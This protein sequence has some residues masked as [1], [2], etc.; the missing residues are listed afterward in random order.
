MTR[1]SKCGYPGSGNVKPVASQWMSGVNNGGSLQK[2]ITIGCERSKGRHLKHYRQKE[3][4][5]RWL[6]LLG[7][8]IHSRRSLSYRRQSIRIWPAASDLEM[9]YLKSITVRI[10]Q[11][12]KIYC[13][14]SEIYVRRYFKSRAYL[15]RLRTYRYA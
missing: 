1:N 7:A 12:L 10:A 15:Y 9:H 14:R 5:S 8:A 2:V 13:V 4:Q 11:R 3:R 6:N